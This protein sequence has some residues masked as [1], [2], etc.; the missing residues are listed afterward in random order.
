MTKTDLAIVELEKTY[1]EAHIKFHDAAIGG[2]PSKLGVFRMDRDVLPYKPDLI[3]IEFAVNDGGKIKDFYDG[4]NEAK[5]KIIKELEEKGKKVNEKKVNKQ[6]L[7]EAS[8]DTLKGEIA[9]IVWGKVEGGIESAIRE[10]VSNDMAV[11]AAKKG[12]E[13]AVSKAVEVAIDKAIEK[14]GSE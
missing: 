4:Y 11:K 7:K 12:A 13:K 2:T 6:A 3:F 8:F 14:L 10:K 1:P 9:D 5:E